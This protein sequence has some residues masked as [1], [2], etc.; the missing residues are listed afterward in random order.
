MEIENFS[1]HQ[2]FK[3]PEDFIEWESSIESEHKNL[4][5]VDSLDVFEFSLK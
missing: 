1:L 3:V 5:T 2:G 4:N